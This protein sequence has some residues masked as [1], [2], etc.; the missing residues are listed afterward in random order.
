MS[1][2]EKDHFF[3]QIGNREGIG[4]PD[5]SEIVPQ[6]FYGPFSQLRVIWPTVD[7][8]TQSI[9]SRYEFI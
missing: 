5:K 8:L 3:D 7:Y 4:D 9:N 2:N 1:F 6:L